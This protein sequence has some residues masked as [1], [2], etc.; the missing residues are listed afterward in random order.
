MELEQYLQ[1]CFRMRHKPS[2]CRLPFALE[3][4]HSCLF[5]LNHYGA[6]AV[7]SPVRDKRANVYYYWDNHIVRG[8]F[9]RER[10]TTGKLRLRPR[11]RRVNDT[12]DGNLGDR[13]DNDRS[14]TRLGSDLATYT[15]SRVW[16]SGDSCF[17]SW[18][19]ATWRFTLNSCNAR[20]A[21]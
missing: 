7:R 3:E 9:D 6:G 14:T 19:Y 10:A 8:Q 20:S 2:L 1:D 17:R 12:V 18:I 16:H 4:Y 13:E 21:K 11:P 5:L 15:G